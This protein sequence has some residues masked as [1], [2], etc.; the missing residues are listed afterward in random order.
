VLLE[1]NPVRFS[2]FVQNRTEQSRT[3]L[4]YKLWCQ[5]SYPVVPIL[6]Q[7]IPFHIFCLYFSQLHLKLHPSTSTYPNWS[8]PLGFPTKTLHLF[9]FSAAVI[10]RVSKAIFI[11]SALWRLHTFWTN[12]VHMV[13][14][15]IY[16]DSLCP[17]PDVGSSH[18][19]SQQKHVFHTTQQL[20][21]LTSHANRTNPTNITVRARG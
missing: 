17:S 16:S 8:A 11:C 12:F 5:N 4:Q 6:S 19:M 21:N 9:L 14:P 20:T 13:V 15:A 10:T 2:E 7:I 18:G 3:V 1:I